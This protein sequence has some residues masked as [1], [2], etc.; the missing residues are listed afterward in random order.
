M[1]DSSEATAER[2]S[3][4][5]AL[6]EMGCA[7]FRAAEI[8]QIIPLRMAKE[9]SPERAPLDRSRGEYQKNEQIQGFELD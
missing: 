3:R 9:K 5:F 4:R 8:E 1:R 2:G 6:V 7:H